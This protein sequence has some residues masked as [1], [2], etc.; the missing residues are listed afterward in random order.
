MERTQH[1]LTLVD[2]VVTIN[3]VLSAAQWRKLTW[4]YARTIAHTLPACKCI[5]STQL[6]SGQRMEVWTATN[7]HRQFSSFSKHVTV[8]ISGST[9]PGREDNSWYV[10]LDSSCLLK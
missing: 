7:A 4:A 5:Y 3:V 10:E 8:I 6:A 1:T 9:F 2:G